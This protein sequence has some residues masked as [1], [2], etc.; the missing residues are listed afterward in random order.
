[1]NRTQV[2]NSSNITSYGYD[3]VTMELEVEFKSKGRTGGPLYK[4]EQV[5]W[6]LVS[7]LND[8]ESKGSFIQQKVVRGGFKF[9]KSEP[10]P[11]AL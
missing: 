9:T 7:E 8:A 2:E 5:P 6:S 1:M 11:E 4:Y 10:E 3:P